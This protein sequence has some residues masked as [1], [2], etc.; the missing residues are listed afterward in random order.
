MFADHPL[1]RPQLRIYRY[2]LRALRDGDVWIFQTVPGQRADDDAALADLS[3]LEVLQHA[4]Q[5]NGGSRL[6]EQALGLR[7]IRDRPRF[8]I[9]PA[10]NGGPSAVSPL[11][12]A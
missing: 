1:D 11:F 12:S 7:K 9:S 8:L 3:E 2:R 4:G 6:A 10:G 5:R